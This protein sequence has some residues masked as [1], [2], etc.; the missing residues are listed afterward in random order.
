MSVS[1]KLL[2]D[3]NPNAPWTTLRCERLLHYI[4]INIASLRRIHDENQ[5][6][7]R[8]LK[9]E[10]VREEGSGARLDTREHKNKPSREHV[11]DEVVQ[12]RSTEPV[13]WSVAGNARKRVS[14]SGFP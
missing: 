10:V 2:L 4:E 14:H 8:R 5:T 12:S 11:Q 13:R 9:E 7:L 1:T 3:P 6:S